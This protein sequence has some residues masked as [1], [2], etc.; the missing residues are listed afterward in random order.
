[1]N[2]NHFPMLGFCVP[3]H[4]PLEK[5]M[6]NPNTQRRSI[7]LFVAFATFLTLIVIWNLSDTEGE[8]QR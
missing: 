3:A 6:E 7:G 1:M 2:K 4:A 5:N 8:F